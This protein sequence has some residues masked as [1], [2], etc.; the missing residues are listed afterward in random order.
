MLKS[1]PVQTRNALD[2]VLSESQIKTSH[3]TPTLCFWVRLPKE[4]HLN[5]NLQLHCY[6]WS[7]LEVSPINQW[8][9][10]IPL[11]FSFQ[12]LARVRLARF[13]NPFSLSRISPAS[14]LH[15]PPSTC[16]LAF[17]SSAIM[18]SCVGYDSWTKK[19]S[20]PS[21]LSPLTACIINARHESGPDLQSAPTPWMLDASLPLEAVKRSMLASPACFLMPVWLLCVWW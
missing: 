1:I 10:T 7:F 15:V 2:A 19:T 11:L 14:Y 3:E 16:N 4:I 21:P 18:R 17:L 5:K 12:F 20:P 9:C 8:H 6:W 13:S